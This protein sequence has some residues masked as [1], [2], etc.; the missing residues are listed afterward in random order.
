M[1]IIDM[2]TLELALDKYSVS[3]NARIQDNISIV[4]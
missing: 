1:E 3:L 2:I 4:I